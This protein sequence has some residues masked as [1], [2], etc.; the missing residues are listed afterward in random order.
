MPKLVIPDHVKAFI[1][2]ANA[3]FDSPTVV[4][5]AVQKE[6]GVAITRQHVESLDPTKVSGTK[7]KR[8]VVLFETARDSFLKRIQQIPGANKAVRLRRL[9]RYITHAETMKN[10]VLAAQLTEQQAKEV[11][12][13]FTNR[14]K[15]EV[16]EKPYEQALAE[17]ERDSGNA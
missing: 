12:E 13:V 15:Q 4:V 8:W 6:F 10:Y 5:E 16:T 9:D 3:C 7:A 11:G 14:V 2:N 17:Y 1:V